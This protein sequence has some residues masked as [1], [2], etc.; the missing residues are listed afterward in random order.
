MKDA[1]KM[2]VVMSMIIAAVFVG[3]GL[4]RIPAVQADEEAMAP[5]TNTEVPAPDNSVA[6]PAVEGDMQQ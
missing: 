6:A 2:L 3:A 4:T 5:A 1:T